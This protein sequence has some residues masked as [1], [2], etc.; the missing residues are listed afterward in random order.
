MSID[1][2]LNFR[3]PSVICNLLVPFLVFFNS[4][5]TTNINSKGP[6]LSPCFTPCSKWNSADLSLFSWT[7]ILT[8]LYRL[9]VSLTPLLILDTSLLF[10]FLL[11]FL[12]WIYYFSSVYL[13]CTLLTLPPTISSIFSQLSPSIACS[14]VKTNRSLYSFR[15]LSD[16]LSCT[17][18]LLN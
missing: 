10:F 18:E 14:K 7:L 17:L 15:N 3:Y 13:F 4:L 2:G 1:T 11:I 12:E 8:F 5:S 6:R 16:P 9:L